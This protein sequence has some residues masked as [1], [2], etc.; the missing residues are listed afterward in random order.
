[1]RITFFVS[2]VS[3]EPSSATK[4]FVQLV[5]STP[6]AH[7]HVIPGNCDLAS[8]LRAAQQ[9]RRIWFEG[10]GPLLLNMI[11]RGVH[12]AESVQGVVLR[13]TSA[14]IRRLPLPQAWGLVTNIIVPTAADVA[15]VR[16]HGVPEHRKVV[17]LDAVGGDTMAKYNALGAILGAKGGDFPLEQWQAYLDHL[18]TQPPPPPCELQGPIVST[19]IFARNEEQTISAAV[20]SF[21]DQT[22]RNL[23]ILVIDDGSTDGTAAAVQPHLVDPRVR[24]IRQEN[25]GIPRTRNRAIELAKGEY[26]AWLGADDESLPQRIEVELKAALASNAD[27]VHTD[28]FQM[29]PDRRQLKEVRR[30]RPVTCQTLPGLLLRGYAQVCPVLDSSLLVRRELYRRLGGYNESFARG[31][32]PEFF[33]RCAEDGNVRFLH[34]AQPLVKV[35]QSRSPGDADQLRA[36]ALELNYS[37]ARRLIERFGPEG[38]MDDVA[39]CLQQDP[40]LTPG[41]ALLALGMTFL[42]PPEHPI[43]AQVS[44][45]L[46]PVAAD[47]APADAAD[48]QNLLGLLCQHQKDDS[49]A[50]RRYE[51]AISLA[52]TEPQKQLART[53]LQALDGGGFA[54]AG[55]R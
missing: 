31:A 11:E 25:M 49:G 30:Y 15:Y 40:R 29:L 2:E 51:A 26:I 12:L 5:S 48:A 42:A 54:G 55:I 50:R 17:A 8:A 33:V 22:Y 34:I 37:M 21:R 13:A 36:R 28:S 10:V 38:V 43:Y 9:S 14:S 23:D 46:E 6:N 32:D 24:L 19:V 18:A 4:T 16:Q 1:M 45:Y 20:Q 53:N 52:P 47:A 35:E 41:R 7:A 39:R 27:I 3:N 44:G